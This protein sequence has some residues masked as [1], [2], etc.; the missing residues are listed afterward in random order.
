VFPEVDLTPAALAVY[1]D[2]AVTGAANTFAFTFRNLG[3]MPSPYTHWTLTA[4][5]TL[6]AEGDTLVAASD[7]LAMSF[8]APVNLAPGDYTL[9]VTL[10]SLRT[11]VETNETNN[12]AVR[13]LHV[14]SYVTGV[15]GLPRTLAL[16][17]PRPNPARDGVRF[18]LDL[19]ELAR[20]DVR[21]LDVQGRQVWAESARPYAAG[22]WTIGWNGRGASGAPVP[23]GIYL[24]Q[25]RVDDHTFVRR[26]AV[27]R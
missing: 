16:S 20:V 25:V 10:D 15:A 19:P 12:V 11:L 22:R 14:R 6:I 7:S 18:T 4:D 23:A 1:P 24:T 5:N 3:R 2:T 26:V 21:V 17:A 9:R 27:M 13:P 8:D